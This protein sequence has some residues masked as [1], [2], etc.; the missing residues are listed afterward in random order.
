M[1]KFS[2]SLC[3]GDG[4]LHARKKWSLYSWLSSTL[5]EALQWACM[6]Y[7]MF[8][9]LSFKSFTPLA[10]LRRRARERCTLKKALVGCGR[11][12]IKSMASR[13]SYFYSRVY[14]FGKWDREKRGRGKCLMIQ[15]L[16]ACLFEWTCRRR[17]FFNKSSSTCFFGST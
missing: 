4:T 1:T 13:S 8:S 9:L 17:I 2:E 10:K 16:L 6:L 7:V 15:F 5:D 11:L 12:R 14:S 3:L